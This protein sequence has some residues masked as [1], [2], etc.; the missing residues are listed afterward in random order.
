M[1]S[2]GVNSRCRR[3]LG[4][5][6]WPRQVEVSNE[7]LQ[8]EEEAGMVELAVLSLG[9]VEEDDDSASSSRVYAPLL[10]DVSCKLH[11]VLL[12]LHSTQSAGTRISMPNL[13]RHI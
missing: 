7:L 11:H 4:Q 13:H 9:S 1:F 12:G 2:L 3:F 8:V 5:K 6:V 10:I